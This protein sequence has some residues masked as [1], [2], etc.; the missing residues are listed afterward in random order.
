LSPSGTAADLRG[1]AFLNVNTAFAVGCSGE[2]LSSTDG[3]NIWQTEIAGTQANLNAVA[4][5]S[6]S[7]AVVVGDSGILFRK[8]IIVS[9]DETPQWDNNEVSLYPNYPNPFNPSTTIRFSLHVS[10][11]VRLS[12][13]NIFG[14]EITVLAEKR[15]PAG[16]HSITWAPSELSQGLYF[17]RLQTNTGIRTIKLLFIK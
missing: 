8:E 12:I 2:I 14:Q 17:A 4:I 3:G 15:F 5:D 1:V 11:N 10:N 16:S 6:S 7:T 9:V 13:Y